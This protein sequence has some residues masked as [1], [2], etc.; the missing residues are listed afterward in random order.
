[1]GY[2]RSNADWYAANGDH[3]SHER[4]AAD[5]REQI[6]RDSRMPDSI[7]D[8]LRREAEQNEKDSR[9]R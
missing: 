2:I 6:R 7:R 1:M 9:S 5:I 3:R 8:D 4:R